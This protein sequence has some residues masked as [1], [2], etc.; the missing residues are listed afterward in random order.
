M[1]RKQKWLRTLSWLRREFPTH[2]PTT[3]R[4]R[5]IKSGNDGDTW[6]SDKSYL[7]VVNR[8]KSYSVRIDTILHEWAHAMTVISGDHSKDHSPAWGVYHAEIYRKF[9]EWNYGKRENA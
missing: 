4:S 9:F 1:T 5:V 8:K 3:V 6:S 2:F 7:I